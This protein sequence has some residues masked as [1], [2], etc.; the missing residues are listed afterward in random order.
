MAVERGVALYARQSVEKEGSISCSTQITYCRAMLTPDEQKGKVWEFTDNGF[1]GGNLNRSGFC[2]MLGLIE[3]GK[4][5]KVI[6]YRLDRISRSLSDFVGVLGTLK[7]Y[8]VAF[9]STQEAFNTGSAYGELVVKILAVFAEFERSIYDQ[10]AKGIPLTADKLEEIYFDLN[11][12]YHGNDVKPDRLIASEWSRIPHFYRSF[13]VYK[14]ATGFSAAVALSRNILAGNTEPYLS[15]L[16][17]GGSKDV[18]DIMK[19]AGVDF[20]TKEPVISALEYFND[21]LEAFDH[22]LKNK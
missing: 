17:A 3:R 7:K 22:I 19:D 21:R 9:V 11:T 13:Y 12:F 10:A 15:F 16:K 14:Y 20:T 6:V 8:G 2:E 4:V 1:S 18:L 5:S